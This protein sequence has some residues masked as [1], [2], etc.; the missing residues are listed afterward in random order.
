MVNVQLED[1]LVSLPSL[2]CVDCLTSPLCLSQG[3][4][5]LSDPRM[6]LGLGKAGWRQGVISCPW[7]VLAHG[8]LGPFQP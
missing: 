1:A 8:N 3:P 6:D 2:S 7:D 4:L 5:Q